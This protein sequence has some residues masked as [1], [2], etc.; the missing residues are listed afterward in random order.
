LGEP[1]RTVDVLEI[2]GLLFWQFK[3]AYSS[4]NFLADLSRAWERAF[5]SLGLEGWA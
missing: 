5:S 4:L 3:G 1:T 2:L